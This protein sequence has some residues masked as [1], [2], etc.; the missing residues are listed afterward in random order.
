MYNFT[1]KWPRIKG[2]VIHDTLFYGS[3]GQCVQEGKNVFQYSDSEPKENIFIPFSVRERTERIGAEERLSLTL[4]LSQRERGFRVDL[5]NPSNRCP[6][7]LPEKC[8]HIS[9]EPFL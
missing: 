2:I 5:S 4:V 8:T 3:S 1:M 6:V 7:S 9:D